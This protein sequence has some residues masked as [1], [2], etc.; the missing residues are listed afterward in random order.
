[1][2]KA[3]RAGVSP[4]DPETRL[5]GFIDKFDPENQRLIRA[6]RP[7]DRCAQRVGCYH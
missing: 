5:R 7:G 1:M 6:V 4:A 2:T 3:Q